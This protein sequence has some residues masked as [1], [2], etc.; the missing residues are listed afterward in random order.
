M[1]RRVTIMGRE[2]EPSIVPPKI[3]LLLE[4]DC[5]RHFSDFRYVSRMMF[6]LAQGAPKAWDAKRANLLN[7]HVK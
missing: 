7:F 1:Y 6:V 4:C 2:K 5:F 3:L